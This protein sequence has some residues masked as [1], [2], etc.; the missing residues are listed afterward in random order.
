MAQNVGRGGNIRS[1]DLNGINLYQEKKRTVY[2]DIFTK[3]SDNVFT[4]DSIE[5][6][7]ITDFVSKISLDLRIAKTF[8]F[9]SM[10]KFL[11]LVYTDVSQ[12]VIDNLR[13]KGIT[14]ETDVNQIGQNLFDDAR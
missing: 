14:Q 5:T 12:R 4:L 10:I 8:K 1:A 3:K 13:E 7:D 2:Y 11:K 6:G 9:D